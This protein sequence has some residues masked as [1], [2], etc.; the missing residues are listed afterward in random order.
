MWI[1][2]KLIFHALGNFVFQWEIWR[3]LVNRIHLNLLNRSRFTLINLVELTV[4]L[5]RVLP[6]SEFRCESWHLRFFHCFVFFSQKILQQSILWVMIAQ[7]VMTNHKNPKV[8]ELKPSL[9]ELH[10]ERLNVLSDFLTQDTNGSL[11][12]RL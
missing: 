12:L 5:L 10:L 1:N 4:V 3:T 11:C 8:R 6:Y 2:S 9:A 7:T